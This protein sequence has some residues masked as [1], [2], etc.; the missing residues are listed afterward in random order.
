MKFGLNCLPNL[1]VETLLFYAFVKSTVICIVNFKKE[2][3]L[4]SF[5]HVWYIYCTIYNAYM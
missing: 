4:K 5:S 2:F 1:N 3:P